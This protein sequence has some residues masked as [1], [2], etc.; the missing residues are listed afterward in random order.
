MPSAA[1]V[2]LRQQVDALARALLPETVEPDEVSFESEVS[3]RALSFRLLSHSEIEHYFERR[4]LEV[5]AAVSVRWGLDRSVSYPGLCLLGFSGHEMKAPPATVHKPPARQIDWSELTDIHKRFEKAVSDYFKYVRRE[6][7]GVN[8]E[9]LLRMLL[10]IGFS[11]TELDEAFLLQ[12]NN[13]A[14]TRGE[15]AHNTVLGQITRGVNPAEERRVVD[16]VLDS[17]GPI[18][19]ELD[20]LHALAS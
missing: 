5:G 17:L 19:L 13:F 2:E 10:P 12:M 20:R 18:D 7:H 6:N 9:N 16:D 3:I 14:R 1:L 8:E 4:A 15:A 11:I